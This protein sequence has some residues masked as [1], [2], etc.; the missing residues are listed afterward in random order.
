MLVNRTFK[1]SM[2]HFTLSIRRSKL[3]QQ[4]VLSW[5]VVKALS[6]K[7]ADEKRQETVLKESQIIQKYLLPILY[8]VPINLQALVYN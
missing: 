8:S 1:P 2:I 7:I 5:L 3:S 4:D 6:I